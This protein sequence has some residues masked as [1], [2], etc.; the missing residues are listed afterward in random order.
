VLGLLAGLLCWDWP[1][2]I[3]ADSLVQLLRADT[4]QTCSAVMP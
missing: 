2:L 3:L 1:E 4:H